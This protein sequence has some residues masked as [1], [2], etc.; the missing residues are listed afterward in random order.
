M[1]S[2]GTP[3]SIYFL[4]SSEYQV[5]NCFLMSF[6]GSVDENV[7]GKFA[8]DIERILTLIGA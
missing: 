3:E 2:V 4:T 1:L 8:D 5:T 7:N 6:C